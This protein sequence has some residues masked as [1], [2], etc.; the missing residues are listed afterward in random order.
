[1]TGTELF[2]LVK[3]GYK[4][5]EIKEFVELQKSLAEENSKQSAEG[6][7]E[8]DKKPSEDDG[9]KGDDLQ[10]KL[11]ELQKKLDE[12]DSLIKELQINNTKKNIEDKLPTESEML[13]EI[14][15]I[16]M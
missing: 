11:D 3:N 13:E 1:M 12:K 4:L 14:G 7:P 15:K 10:A 8:D 2:E 5:N 16:F 6:N 9:A